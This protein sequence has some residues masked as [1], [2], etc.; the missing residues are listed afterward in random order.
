LPC[1]ILKHG[2]LFAGTDAFEEARAAKSDLSEFEMHYPDTLPATLWVIL[3]V[4]IGWSVASAVL[5][6]LAQRFATTR[7]NH[8]P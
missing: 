6:G 1:L 3:A 8:Q 4:M 7:R 2:L 5:V